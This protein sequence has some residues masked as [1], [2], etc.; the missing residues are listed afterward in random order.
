M[1]KAIA[2]LLPTPL[3]HPVTCHPVPS[4]FGMRPQLLTRRDPLPA[5]RAIPSSLLVAIEVS[6][7]R[8]CTRP[9]AH[10]SPR[11]RRHGELA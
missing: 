9:R 3:P 1:P 2:A 8:N 11:R 10:W 4:R 7:H 5:G 6:S